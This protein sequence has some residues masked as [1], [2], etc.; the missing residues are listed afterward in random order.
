MYDPFARYVA[1]WFVTMYACT[2]MH[3]HTHTKPWGNAAGSQQEPA[4]ETPSLDELPEQEDDEVVTRRMQFRMKQDNK[5][6][7]A[8]KK[9]LKALEKEKKAQEKTEKK[10]MRIKLAEEKKAAKKKEKEEKKASKKTSKKAE[11]NKIIETEKVVKKRRKGSMKDGDARGKEMVQASGTTE[12]TKETHSVKPDHAV[13]CAEAP[14]PNPPAGESEE[15]AP[16]AEEGRKSG[17]CGVKSRK[18]S[19]LKKM[20]SKWGLE[21][22]KKTRK[23]TKKGGKRAAAKKDQKHTKARTTEESKPLPESDDSTGADGSET[24]TDQKCQN[25]KRN[26]AAKKTDQESSKKRNAKMISAQP[27][28][29]VTAHICKV[30]ESCSSSECTHPEWEQPVFDRK[31]FQFSVY[32]TRKAVGVKVAKDFLAKGAG[33]K[34]QG[35]KNGKGTKTKWQQVAYFCQSTTCIYTNYALA[36]AFAPSQQCTTQYVLQI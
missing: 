21:T 1:A 6:K 32:W 22:N 28:P 11:E 15:L 30:L 12:D 3:P 19:K 8:E 9:Q 29:E 23:E 4:R 2:I 20:K 35:K 14:E 5:K 25:R 18:L 26:K 13:P 10:N 17:C 27:C 36:L 16:R 33:K 34:A 24:Q 7:K 31:I